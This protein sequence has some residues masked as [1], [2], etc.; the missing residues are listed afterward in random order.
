MSNLSE[1]IT[2]QNKLE[3]SI[4]KRLDDLQAQISNAGSSK[5][6]VAKVGEEL[7]NFREII[8]GILSL[9]RQQIRE[10]AKNVDD[11]DTRNRRKALIVS[12][13]PEKDKEDCTQLILKIINEKIGINNLTKSSIKVCHRLGTASEQRHRPIL[14]R[15]ESMDVKLAVWK[16]KTKLRGSSMSLKEF[17][18]RTRQAVFSK[19]RLHFGMRSVWTHNGVI[20]IKAP[21]GSSHRIT[22]EEELSTLIAKYPKVSGRS[23]SK[24]TNSSTGKS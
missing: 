4:T 20:V 15:F 1:I 6:T 12:G 19:S 17:L 9:L 3:E 7:R 10:C 14:V 23:S 2:T 8:F 21:C 18:T 16:A 13:V 5:D 11:L 24:I 22:T